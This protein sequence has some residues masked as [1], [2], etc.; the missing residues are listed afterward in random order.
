MPLP[1]QEQEAQP[2]FSTHPDYRQLFDTLV[3]GGQSREQANLLLANLWHRRA[4]INAP[5]QQVAPQL[6]EPQQQQHL[7]DEVPQQGHVDQNE[8]EQPN[9]LQ[10][11]PQP[12]IRDHEEQLGAQHQ[13]HRQAQA[14]HPFPPGA[15]PV[16]Q[17]LPPLPNDDQ[18]WF[19][20]DKA[21]KRAPQLPPIDL[22]AESLTMSL[23]RPTTYAIEKFRKFEYVPLW[24][25]TEQ[26]CQTADKDKA[27][28]ED[29]WDVTKTSDNRLSLRTAA[30]NRPSPNALSDEQLTWEQ[31]MDANHLLCRWLIPAGWPEGYAKILSSFFWQIENHEDKGIAEGKETLLLYQARARKAWHE[32]L[33]AGHFFNLAKLNEKKMNAY[34]KEVDAKHNVIVRKALNPSFTPPRHTILLSWMTGTLLELALVFVPVHAFTLTHAFV[35][36]T[37]LR[38]R[39]HLCALHM[40]LNLHHSMCR[41]MPLRSHPSDAFCL[42]CSLSPPCLFQTSGHGFARHPYTGHFTKPCRQGEA[43][44]GT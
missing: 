36:C 14:P 25:F 35:L 12:P 38:A 1:E 16:P 17:D 40:P 24:Y 31:F 22:D 10:L 9:Q 23:Q 20:P 32:E 43:S 2:D 8:P 5:Q 21:D 13:D 3:A 29:L 26:G 30:A 18:D 19:T 6:H 37:C 39:P 28:N 44:T 11:P 41:F 4:N 42:L 7:G 33:K 34:R 15:P 27:S